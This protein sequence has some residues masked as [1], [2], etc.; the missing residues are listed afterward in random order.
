MNG[1]SSNTGSITKIGKNEGINEVERENAMEMVDDTTAQNGN[2]LKDLLRWNDRNKGRHQENMAAIPVSGG[3]IQHKEIQKK[4]KLPNI[5]A[6]RGGTSN[7]EK[8]SEIS[9]SGV[10][11]LLSKLNIG[12]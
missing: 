5:L 2:I 9:M 10:E 1:E 12:K 6:T 7:K 8:V 3:R 4:Q 11:G